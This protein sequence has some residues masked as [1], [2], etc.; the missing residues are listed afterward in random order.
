MSFTVNDYTIIP[1]HLSSATQMIVELWDKV[2]RPTDPLSSSGKKVVHFVFECY[3]EL[4]PSEFKQ[5]LDERKEY[6]VHEKSIPEQVRNHTGRSL[7]SYPYWVFMVLRNVFP[8][9]DFVKRE[10][11]LKIAACFP[12]FQIANKR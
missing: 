6:Q 8:H 10:N 2:G 3:K 9:F 12:Q 1:P 5:W 4:F 11:A 7:L